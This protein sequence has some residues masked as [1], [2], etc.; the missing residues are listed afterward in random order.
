MGDLDALRGVLHRLDRVV[1]AFSGGADSAFLAWVAHDTLGPHRARAV[2]ALSPSLPADER[3]YCQA[4][5]D[6]WGLNWSVVETDELERAAYRDN[7]GD[8]CY[9]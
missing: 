4:L 8:R 6:E 2:T 7:D 5:V 3:L 1:V 9:H